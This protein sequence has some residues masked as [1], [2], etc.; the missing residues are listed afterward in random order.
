MHSP[1]VGLRNRG[2][3]YAVC[4]SMCVFIRLRHGGDGWAFL[5]VFL[6]SEDILSHSATEIVGNG[7]SLV[8]YIGFLISGCIVSAD[9]SGFG[10][11]VFIRS[12]ENTVA[13]M[14]TIYK[15][16]LI[17]LLICAILAYFLNVECLLRALYKEI[18]IWSQH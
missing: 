15:I 12:T 6:I 8:G 11:S 17:K 10:Y 18:Y 13:T 16:A 14:L 7:T 9:S 1:V 4:P 3:C 2:W 5:P